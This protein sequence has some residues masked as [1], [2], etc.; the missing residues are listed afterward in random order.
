M[1]RGLMPVVRN[2]L[3]LSSHLPNRD[4]P[5]KHKSRGCNHKGQTS[6]GGWLLAAWSEMAARRAGSDE[7]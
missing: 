3:G 1:L 7:K 5:K 6:A 4:D 2:T